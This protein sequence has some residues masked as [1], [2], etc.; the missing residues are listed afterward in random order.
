M[1]DDIYTSRFFVTGDKQDDKIGKHPISSEWWSRKY[2]YPWCAN[3][4]EKDDICLDSA[5]GVVHPFK[6]FLA[7]ICKEVHACDIDEDITR[8]SY[9]NLTVK[10]SDIVDLKEYEDN[11]FDKV[12][13]ISTLEHLEGKWKDAELFI[14]S[15]QRV[16]KPNGYFVLTFD[17]SDFD[18]VDVVLDLLSKYFQFAG[19]VDKKIYSDVL[20]SP[21]GNAVV[22]RS[23]V[24]KIV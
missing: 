5:S 4:V 24:K 16:L 13:N 12:Y 3:F 21:K 10:K 18:S 17:V 23:I 8:V 1:L 14:Q 9:N 20:V 2:E 15:A 11:Y 7:D 22:F 6:Y 19:K